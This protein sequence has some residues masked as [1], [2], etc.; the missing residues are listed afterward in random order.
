D[1]DRF[2][3]SS[4]SD[5]ISVQG[6]AYVHHRGWRNFSGQTACDSFETNQVQFE[7]SINARK[8]IKL[9]PFGTHEA[10]WN[11]L[12]GQFMDINPSFI[13]TTFAPV[14]QMFDS[15]NWSTRAQAQYLVSMIQDL[16]YAYILQ[17]ESCSDKSAEGGCLTGIRYGLLSPYEFLHSEKGDCD[18]RA[19]LLCM[20]LKKIGLNP[21]IAVSEVYAHAMLMIDLPSTGAYIEEQGIRYY[22]WETTYPDWDIGMIPPDCNNLSNWSI[23]I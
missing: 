18:T 17:S 5:D 23:V 8:S 14:Y 21:R 11:N 6:D 20:L 12:Y 7:S 2:T 1:S 13:E 10:F 9:R 3:V 16:P 19:V 22:F 4:C 15:L